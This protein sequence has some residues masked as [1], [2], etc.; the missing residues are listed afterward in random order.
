[1]ARWFESRKAPQRGPNPKLVTLM[2]FMIRTLDAL[3]VETRNLL[4]VGISGV[5]W[6]T[7]KAK[8]DVFT[9]GLNL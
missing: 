7:P 1:M 4:I 3:Y 2:P 5:K 8:P 9:L 6:K